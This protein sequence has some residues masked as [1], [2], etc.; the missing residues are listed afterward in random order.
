[1]TNFELHR[2]YNATE[3]LKDVSWKKM[4][5]RMK[6]A[7]WRDQT[8]LAYIEIRKTLKEMEDLAL[9]S[10]LDRANGEIDKAN[11]PTSLPDDVPEKAELTEALAKFS[12]SK[13]DKKIK[14]KV[15]IPMSWLEDI[16]EDSKV[17]PTVEDLEAILE[18]VDDDS[19]QPA[20]KDK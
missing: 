17:N 9:K 10:Y 11:P 16:H 7:V 20:P 2:F 4:G 8:R 19:P 13:T 15:K 1:M 12:Q 18:Y 14:I 6:L 5:V 3:V